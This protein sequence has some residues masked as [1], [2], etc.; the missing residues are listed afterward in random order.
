MRQ[1][2]SSMA[3]VY[4]AASYVCWM[5]QEKVIE[6]L[7]LPRHGFAYERL[8]PAHFNPYPDG[9]YIEWWNDRERT[10][11]EGRSSGTRN[12]FDRFPLARPQSGQRGTIGSSSCAPELLGITGP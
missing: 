3:Y 8:D 7:D 11:G 2:N 5:L 12:E 1:R 4:Q 10:R 6:D 9:S